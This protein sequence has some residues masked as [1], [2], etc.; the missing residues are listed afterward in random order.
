VVV[1][2]TLDP[3]DDPLA[4]LLTAAGIDHHRGS[5]HDVLTRTWEAVS[6][7]APDFVIR[8]TADNPF[9]DAAV[10][11]AQ[12]ERCRAGPFDYVGT[13]GWPLGIAAEVARAS[14]LADAVREA[15]DPAEREHVMPFLYARPARYRLGTAPPAVPPPEGRFTVDTVEDLAFVRAIAQRLGPVETCAIG[16]LR[17]I[18][19]DEP[20]LLAINAGIRQ[21]PWQEAQQR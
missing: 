12:L 20:G 3:S 21:K 1:A 14:S 17:A 15:T 5:V 10:V 16:D 8:A 6:P 13:T 4:E 18:V 7:G 9:M 11:G 19:E 2:T